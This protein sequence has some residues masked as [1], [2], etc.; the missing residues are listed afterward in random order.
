MDFCVYVYLVWGVFGASR[1]WGFYYSF[2]Q[3]VSRP[4]GWRARFSCCGQFRND[5]LGVRLCN[6]QYRSHWGYYHSNDEKA[7]FPA[8]FAAAVEV[9]ASTGGQLIPPIMGAGVFIMASY[10]QIPYL[11]I[12]GAAF[13]PAVLYFLSIAIFVRI[14]AK[15]LAIAPTTDEQ[16]PSAWQEFKSGWHHLLP[17]GLLVA[18]MVYGFTPT[19]AVSIATLSVCIFWFSTAPMGWGKIA[20][21]LAAAANNCA[22]TAV[23]LVA[24]GVL[25]NCISLSSLGVTFSLMINEWAGSNLLLLWP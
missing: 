1:Y 6:R 2:C 17:I 24:I 12:I 7:G 19:Y 16:H 18:L 21:A 5:G 20:E 11:T 4:Y 25:V 15:R 14:Q 9:G 10:T 22:K 23:L 3:C 8:K 13:V